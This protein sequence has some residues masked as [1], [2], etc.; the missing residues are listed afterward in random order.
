MWK[1]VTEYQDVN[2]R[3]ATYGEISAVSEVSAECIHPAPA[4]Y[5][6]LI[7]SYCEYDSDGMRT[8]NMLYEYQDMNETSPTYGQISSVTEVSSECEASSSAATWV[9]T[10]DQYC[11]QDSDEA[12]TGYMVIIQ[13]DKNPFSPT[14]METR[15]LKELSAD[16]EVTNKNPHWTTLSEQCTIVMSNCVLNYNGTAT[17]LQ[18]DDNPYSPTFNVTRTITEQSEACQPCGSEMFRWVEVSGEYMCVGTTKCK[19]MKKQVS[20][21]RGYSWSDVVPYEYEAGEAI[22]THSVDCGYVPPVEPEYRWVEKTGVTECSGTTK[23]SVEKLQVSYDSGSTWSDVD[24]E[25]TR[26]GDVIEYDSTDCGYVPDPIY[27]WIEVSGEYTCVGTTKCKKMKKQYSLDNGYSWSD[28]IPYEYE[29]G[30]AIEIHSTDCGYIVPIYRWV[31]DGTE[32]I[33][34]GASGY[35]KYQQEKEQVSYDNGVSWQDVTPKETRIGSLI[36]T[37]STDCGYVPVQT[38]YKW[39][40]IDDVCGSDSRLDDAIEGV[41]GTV[42]VPNDFMCSG[43]SKYEKDEVIV[44]FSGEV[45]HTGEYV[46]GDL[47]E[48]GSTDCGYVPPL[49]SN[50]KARL[51]LTGGST[52]D[53]PWNNITSLKREEVKS[54]SSETISIQIND[55]VTHLTYEYYAGSG[56]GMCDSFS[57]LSSVT[58]PNSVTSIG[59]GSFRYC[60]SLSSI[61][62]PDSV[63]TMGDNVFQNSHL[64]NINIGSGVTSIG[65]ETFDSCKRLTS[66]TIPDNVTS[67]GQSAFTYSGIENIHIGSGVTGIGSYAFSHCTHLTSVTIPDSV[68]RL[69]YNAFEYCS[70]LTNVTIGNGVTSIPTSAFTN[71]TNLTSTTIGSGVTKISGMA[72]NSCSSLS[73]ITIPNSVSTIG[74]SVFIDCSGLQSVIIGSGVTSI[75][76]SAFTGCS[77][78]Q[79]ITA[80]PMTAP[81]IGATTFRDVKS[82]GTLYV[83]NGSNGYAQWMKTYDYYLGKYNWTREY[84]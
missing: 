46:L 24:P 36:E 1:L 18:I 32:F 20:T 34:S 52:V 77:S 39:E 56:I 59:F 51:T 35:D 54:Y 42:L 9:N 16:C 80:L 44:T 7:G 83:Q 28:V 72:F 49:P 4:P 68:T 15:E 37:G 25:E 40:Y 50:V 58:I 27:R 17:K 8:G 84:I 12:Y 61:T 41:T 48:T 60:V 2:P 81:D 57:R 22:A 26:L 31:D 43:T 67:I 63:I 69:N 64:E 14:Y 30:E 29:P 79:S 23:Y 21:D 73:S 33:C 71:C 66:I 53:I 78:L 65:T 10:E 19:K 74:D 47:I 55:G 11:E 45:Y 82:R 75:G 3:S 62:I 70:G 13:Y 6:E 5:Y 38:I 76:I